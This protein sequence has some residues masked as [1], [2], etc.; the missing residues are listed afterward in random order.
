MLIS[1]LRK[2]TEVSINKVREALAASNNVSAALN[3][4]HVG[5]SVLSRGT[6]STPG[7]V[8]AALVELNCKTEFVARNALF[9]GRLVAD[10]AHTT[11]FLA[12]SGSGGQIERHDEH[13]KTYIFR[14]SGFSMRR[15]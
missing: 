7:G 13:Q 5:A 3:E 1:E 11:A 12:E 8:C 9:F 10:V 6:G 14:A 15:Y 2:P 4:G